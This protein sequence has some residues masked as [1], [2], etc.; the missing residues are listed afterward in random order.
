MDNKFPG[1]P[2]QYPTAHCHKPNPDKQSRDNL[3]VLT[4]I[5]IVDSVP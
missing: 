2:T 1:I 5:N 3:A 4:S